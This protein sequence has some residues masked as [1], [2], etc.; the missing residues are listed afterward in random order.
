MRVHM[1]ILNLCLMWMR[2]RAHLFQCG[3]KFHKGFFFLYIQ[4]TCLIWSA[5]FFFTVQCVLLLKG[6]LCFLYQVKFLKMTSVSFSHLIWAWF[7]THAAGDWSV[8]CW[9]TVKQLQLKGSR[10]RCRKTT[11]EKNP[12]LVSFA[13]FR[14]HILPRHFISY[15]YLLIDAPDFFSFSFH[16]ALCP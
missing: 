6:Y 8:S 11:N 9:I 3:R 10:L 1:H 4:N 5:L 7:N 14:T 16:H 13:A 12:E 2:N 15:G